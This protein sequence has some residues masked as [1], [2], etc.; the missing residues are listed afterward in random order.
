MTW[1]TINVSVITY[2]KRNVHDLFTSPEIHAIRDIT[3]LNWMRER[4]CPPLFWCR[5][6]RRRNNQNE[7]GFRFT[8]SAQKINWTEII[9]Q[10]F[11]LFEWK[12]STL[13]TKLSIFLHDWE[14]HD[15]FDSLHLYLYL[16][17]HSW[18]CSAPHLWSI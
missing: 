8:A 5:S 7:S 2:W 14:L 9:I 12:H 10:F 15:V 17:S 18:R 4:N 1:N 3:R 11:W 6:K 13:T 16:E